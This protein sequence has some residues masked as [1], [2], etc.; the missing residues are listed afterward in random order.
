MEDDD[1]FLPTDAPPGSPQKVAVM[2]NRY[3]RCVE[4]RRCRS[5]F[6]AGDVEEWPELDDL[7]V[8]EV[9]RRLD[10]TE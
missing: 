2:A 6:V 8:C 5:L 7:V 4:L 3:R 1:P 9:R 10:D